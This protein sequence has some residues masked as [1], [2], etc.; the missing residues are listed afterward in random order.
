[1]KTHCPVFTFR[2]FQRGLLQSGMRGIAWALDSPPKG[3]LLFSCWQ[4]G[5]EVANWLTCS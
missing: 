2:L 4:F 5:V 3:L 1:Y